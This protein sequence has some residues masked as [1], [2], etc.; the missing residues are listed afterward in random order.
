MRKVV[1][2]LVG[3]ALLGVAG[4]GGGA[5]ESSLPDLKPMRFPDPA[6]SPYC[7]PYPIGVTAAVS[8]A[9]GDSG[10]HRGRFAIDFSMPFGTEIT[11]ARSGVVT[12]IRDQYSDDDRTGG[13]EN[14]VFVL[15]SDGTMASYLH[16]GEDGVLVDVG[17]EVATGEVIGLVGTTGTS[18][19]HLHFEVFEGQGEGTQWYRTIPV[20]FANAQDPLDDWGGL[21]RISYESRPCAAQPQ[22]TEEETSP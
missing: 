22:T 14:G 3:L 9:W 10:T 12:E 4:C 17:D 7:L 19:P 5:T 18:V 15:H 13:H 1:N 11:A 2:T 8:Q 6:T 21:R 20:S 16:L